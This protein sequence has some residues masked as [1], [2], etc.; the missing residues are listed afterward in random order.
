MAVC[1]TLKAL[2]LGMPLSI[3]V[4]LWVGILNGTFA[5]LLALP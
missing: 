3:A 4:I 1:F 2:R 5:L